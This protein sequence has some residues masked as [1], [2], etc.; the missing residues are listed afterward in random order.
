MDCLWGISHILSLLNQSVIVYCIGLLL[1]LEIQQILLLLLL[2]LLLIVV[3][4]V[5]VVAIILVVIIFHL[6][7]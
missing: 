7:F 4:V 2:L 1:A 6:V 3:V 5:V